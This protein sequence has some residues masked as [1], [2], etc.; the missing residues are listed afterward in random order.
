MDERTF[1]RER[2]RADLMA[3]TDTDRAE[4]WLGFR[5]GLRRAYYGK[6]FGSD[7]EHAWWL[8]MADSIDRYHAECGRGYR[9]GLAV[10]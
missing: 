4:Y 2:S 8:A 6:V 7:A 10:R 9:D 5:R 1:E 3:K